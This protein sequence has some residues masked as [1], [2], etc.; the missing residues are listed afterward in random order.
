M[1]RGFFRYSPS[2]EDV[3]FGELE[4]M[5]VQAEVMRLVERTPE[6]REAPV[7]NATGPAY[8]SSRR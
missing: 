8:G 2:K 7:R 6:P 4:A 5:G 1:T 3:L